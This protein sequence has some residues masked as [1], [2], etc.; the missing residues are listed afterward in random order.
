MGTAILQRQHPPQLLT[1]L[2]TLMHRLLTLSFI[3]LPALAVIAAPPEPYKAKV[4]PASDEPT[5]A[6]KNFRVPK[7]MTIDAWAAEPM[8]ANPVVF[9][10]D[11]K[12]RFYVAETFR[13]HQGVTDIR[14]IMG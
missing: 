10:I 5:R 12:N 1:P 6:V 2:A 8:L 11:H 9:A 14:G 4:A 7:G 13:L 3:L